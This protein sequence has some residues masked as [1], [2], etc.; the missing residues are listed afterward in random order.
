MLLT[1]KNIGKIE[2]AEIEL[3]GITVLAGENNTGKSTV[4]KV[5]CAMFN[6]LHGLE[7]YVEQQRIQLITKELSSLLKK[8]ISHVEMQKGSRKEALS[9]R[10]GTAAFTRRYAILLMKESE[11]ENICGIV[12]ECVEKGLKKYLKEFDF[13]IQNSSECMEYIEETGRRV[14][15]SIHISD[16]EIAAMRVS[17]IFERNFDEQIINLCREVKEAEAAI[18]IKG[19]RNSVLFEK[20]YSDKCVQVRR[21]F[22]VEKEAFY[23]DNPRD[24]EQLEADFSYMRA[25]R[26][27]NYEAVNKRVLKSILMPG[28]GISPISFAWD[29]E[30][31]EIT[32]EQDDI[33]RLLSEKRLEKV[34][35]KIQQAMGGRFMYD[36]NEL[37]FK[38]ENIDGA[39]RVKNLSTGMKSL[40]LLERTVSNGIVQDKSVLVLDEPEIN[41][42][43]EW[44]I[45]YAEIIVLLQKE[46][47]LTIVISTHS[48]YFLQAISYYAEQYESEEKCHYYLAENC[49]GKAVFH[50]MDNETDLIFKKLTLP[51]LRITE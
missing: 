11:Q 36:S 30:S 43:P 18:I 25:G 12:R 45:L 39:I 14:L 37:V 13:D 31:E 32:D 16:E 7:E 50:N 46:F 4:G 6:S 15:E 51:F 23:F 42:H 22:I 28:I 33:Q 1:I 41:L 3:D 17:Q 38:E 2:E 26:G 8:I 24:I 21:E 49:G 9:W 35:A 48:P 10:A 27:R 40:A 19:K 34:L 44:Q 29:N 47:D 5:L 20:E